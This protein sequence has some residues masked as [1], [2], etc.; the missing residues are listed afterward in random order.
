MGWMQCFPSGSYLGSY[1]CR[2]PN[3]T[4]GAE[5]DSVGRGLGICMWQAP[6]GTPKLDDPPRARCSCSQASSVRPWVDN[7][8][9]NQSEVRVTGL[10]FCKDRSVPPPQS[11]TCH[12]PSI[13]SF[14]DSR[15]TLIR[16]SIR[17]APS[18][19]TFSKDPPELGLSGAGRGH[20]I[21]Q[22]SLLVG[23]PQF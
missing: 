11:F 8:S 22:R 1:L 13:L 4:P 23:A 18:D 15:H 17:H 12:L 14:W 3:R 20:A 7:C 6:W 2:F 9:H 5:S 19:T 10:P 21:Q 16:P